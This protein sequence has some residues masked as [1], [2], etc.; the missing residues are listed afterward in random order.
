MFFHIISRMEPEWA[1]GEDA[2]LG[3][4][5]FDSKTFLAISVGSYGNFLGAADF[6]PVRIGP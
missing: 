6:N 3:G 5:D 2:D 1:N 4:G